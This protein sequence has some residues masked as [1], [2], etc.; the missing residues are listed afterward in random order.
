MD[1]QS[2]ERLL[3][4]GESI[5]RIAK[6]FGKDPSTVSYWMKKY[7]LTSPYAEKHAARG[8]IERERLD[9]LVE[10]GLSIA[11]IAAA[12]GR[13]KS[14]V[15]HWLRRYE[16][17]TRGSAG[18]KAVG[19]KR[20]ARGAGALTIEMS[21][22]HRGE[23]TFV[24]EG[25]GYYRCR[26]CRAECVVRHRQKVKATLVAEA[27]GCCVLCGHDRNIRAL[28]FHHRYPSE[29]RL[30]VSG[31]GVTYS[32]ETLRAEAKKCVLLCA[33]CH[34]DIEAGLAKLP[35]ELSG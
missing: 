23:T 10:A 7:G 35:L 13:S 17:Q 14:A 33:N 32:M 1:K 27:G 15:R 16:L 21:C 34:V 11:E 24:L 2:L 20:A 4:R 9:A 29:K 28:Q 3:D 12:V 6:R 25:R 26:R 5:E 30:E 31:R 18:R 8:G 22:P 19:K